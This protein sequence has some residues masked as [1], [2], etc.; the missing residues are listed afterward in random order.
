MQGI[1]IN[2]LFLGLMIQTFLKGLQTFGNYFQ[3]GSNHIQ[4]TIHATYKISYQT[5]NQKLRYE[6]ISFLQV[7]QISQSSCLSLHMLITY[8]IST[9][10]L[11]QIQTVFHKCLRVLVM[12]SLL[13]GDSPAQCFAQRQNCCLSQATA[14]AVDTFLMVYSRTLKTAFSKLLQHR[15]DLTTARLLRL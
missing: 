3:I 6:L 12:Q 4:S 7:R 8:F 14:A 11:Y 13:D 9:S 5:I 1:I 10:F 2:Y 15:L